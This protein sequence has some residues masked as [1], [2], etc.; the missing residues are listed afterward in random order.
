MIEKAL[1]TKDYLISLGK[2]EQENQVIK[3]MYREVLF[4]SQE[5]ADTEALQALHTD[6]KAYTYYLAFIHVVDKP[7]V[8]F[9]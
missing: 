7:E 2:N 9:L 4:S 5:L 1:P 3:E 6:K 8:E